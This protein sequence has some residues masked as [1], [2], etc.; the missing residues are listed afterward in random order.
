MFPFALS[1]FLYLFCLISRGFPVYS[2]PDPTH[3]LIVFTIPFPCAIIILLS[4]C[5]DINLTDVSAL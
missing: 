5:A 4:V 2:M 3:F 1:S